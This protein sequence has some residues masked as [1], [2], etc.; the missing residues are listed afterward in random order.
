VVVVP[1]STV[2]TVAV[3]YPK[4]EVLDNAVLT[5]VEVVNVTVDRAGEKNLV[6]IAP[7]LVGAVPKIERMLASRPYLPDVAD[8]LVVRLSQFVPL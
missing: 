8:E 3:P 6:S 1:V 7:A 4:L 2:V 5:V